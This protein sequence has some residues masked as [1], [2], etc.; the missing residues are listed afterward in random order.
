MKATSAPVDLGLAPRIPPQDAAENH[1]NHADSY[2]ESDLALGHRPPPFPVNDAP[3][4]AR[5]T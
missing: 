3:P 5:P 1:E 2:Q 4:R